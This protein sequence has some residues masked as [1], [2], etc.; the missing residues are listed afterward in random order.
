[1]KPRLSNGK[2]GHFPLSKLHELPNLFQKMRIH[3]LPSSLDRFEY[4]VL[5]L[6]KH[7][8][9]ATARVKSKMS[10]AEWKAM[11]RKLDKAGS[12]EWWQ[13]KQ[14]WNQQFPPLAQELMEPFISE[15][16][17]PQSLEHVVE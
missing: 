17:F 3:D 5:S 8:G 7:E 15:A 11:I 10:E 6:A 9:L 13:A 2:V 4:V 1:M 12:P 14:I 16:D